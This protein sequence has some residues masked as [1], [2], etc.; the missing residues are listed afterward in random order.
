MGGLHLASVIVY[1]VGT[2]V[3]LKLV[4]F[5]CCLLQAKRHSK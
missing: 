4:F 1:K 3:F 5:R 2:G